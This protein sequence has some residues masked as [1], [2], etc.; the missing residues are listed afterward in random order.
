MPTQ[1]ALLPVA[2]DLSALLADLER[3]LDLY[4][5]DAQAVTGLRVADSGN[6]IPGGYLRVGSRLSDVIDRAAGYTGLFQRFHPFLSC[7]GFH[8]GV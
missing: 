8:N 4:R 1:A 3:A 7:P 2:D 5:L 6:H